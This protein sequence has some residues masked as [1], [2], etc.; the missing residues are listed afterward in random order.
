MKINLDITINNL[1]GNAFKENNKE[2]TL[3]G[4]LTSCLDNA[5]EGGRM[6]LF[7]LAKKCHKGGK[8]EF[9]EADISMMRKILES[10]PIASNVLMGNAI[11]LLDTESK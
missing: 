9:D 8:V 5:K 4:L 7:V 6:K 3:G 11:L 1:D 10:S 2:I